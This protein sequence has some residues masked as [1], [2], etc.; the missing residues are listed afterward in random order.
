MSYAG[1]SHCT[2]VNRNALPNGR[3]GPISEPMFGRFPRIGSAASGHIN[4]TATAPAACRSSAAT[5][6]PSTAVSSPY[7]AVAP[8]VRQVSAAARAIC[9]ST[10]TTGGAAI[11]AARTA[12]TTI[13]AVYTPE[14]RA[15]TTAFATN[16][17]LRLGVAMN[18]VRIKPLRYSPVTV[19]AARTIST[20]TPNTATPRAAFSGGRGAA[21]YAADPWI[22]A[23][24]RLS[25]ATATAVHTGDRVVDSLIR[26]A[27]R[28]ATELTGAPPGTR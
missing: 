25:P 11:R 3:Y 22:A 4:S 19:I 13:K 12:P 1:Y 14:N 24:P 20:G 17:R 18:V 28:R 16:T 9:D 5:P 15:V 8:T 26:S 2:R 10:P 27:S 23:R 6:T 7:R 21:P